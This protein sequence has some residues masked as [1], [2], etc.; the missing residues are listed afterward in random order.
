M[1]SQQESSQLAWEQ[2]E[3]IFQDMKVGTDVADLKTDTLP[4]LD[5]YETV[6]VLMSDLEPLKEGI[7]EI[8]N[9]V[10]SGGSA[11]FAMALQKDTYASLIEQKLG[12]ISS[13]YEN[14]FVDSIYFD[15]DF[16]IGGGKNYA[17]TDGFDSARQLELSE[18]AQVYAW[19]KEPGGIPLIWEN[20][21]GDG[22]FVVDNFGLY[23]KA[24][25]GFYA[26]SYSLLTDIGVYPV[27]NGS[28]FY[29]D[30]FPSPVPSGDGTYVKRDYGTSIQEFYSNI[31]WPDM[32]NLASQY[33]LKYTG[34]MIE[35]YED[36]TD[37]EITKQTDNERFQYFGN[38][39]LHQGVN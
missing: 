12:I 19:A 9:W 23:E 24:V 28:A 4:N 7:I 14:S 20:A 31:W 36:K 17:I 27:I 3:R 16:L 13:G 6:V 26:A 5:S 38:M 10:K 25:R 11:M 29:L 21:Y 15:S 35:N 2:F 1:D 30:D 18:K 22:K 37:G 34:V 39:V 8:S 32:L 33:G